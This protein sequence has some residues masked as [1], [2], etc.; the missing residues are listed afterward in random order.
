MKKLFLL[1]ASTICIACTPPVPRIITQ[2]VDIPVTVPCKTAAII[3]PKWN[4]SQLPGRAT[5]GEKIKA[6]IA[7]LELSKGYITQLSA[8]VAACK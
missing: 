3:E 2:Q 1:T 5:Y 4:V 6:I 8:A 7:D